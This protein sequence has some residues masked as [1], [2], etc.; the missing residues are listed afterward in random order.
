KKKE[1]KSLAQ[2]WVK[3]VAIDW[4]L[5]YEAG[6]RPHKVRLPTYP[7]ARERYWIPELEEAKLPVNTNHQ[8][9]P[10]LHENASDLLEQKYSSVFSGKET[11]FSDHQ[12]EGEKV[13]P[14]V[15]YL[16]MA[17]EAGERSLHQPITQLRDIMWL[18]PIRVNGL[19]KSIQ[20]SV[21]EAGEGLGYEVYSLPSVQEGRNV[22]ETEEVI[23]SQGSLITAVQPPLP[24]VDVAG[25]QNR[26]TGERVGEECYALFK[27]LGFGYG[28]TFRGIETLYYSREEALS[29]LSLSREEGYVLPPGLLDSALQTCIGLGLAT[30][31]KTLSLPFSVKEVTLYGAVD[32]SR[33]T[34]AR[35]S[36]GVPF[37]ERVTKY[38][39]DMLS[40]AGAVLLSFRDLVLLPVDGFQ[41]K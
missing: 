28:S 23:H 7:F 30:E 16:E 37:G 33:W 36:S 27:E 39:I 8:L 18:S 31:E 15:A 40:E 9:H 20:V 29:R 38:D 22:K 32:E 10:L 24:A 21:F 1:S 6:Q 12:V 26:L 35:R 4:N 5:L 2:L 25:I 3:G 34:Y 17:R 14:G 41:R 19:A 11:F 13:L